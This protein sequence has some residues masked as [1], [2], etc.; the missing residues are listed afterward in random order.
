MGSVIFYTTA[1]RDSAFSSRSI[2]VFLSLTKNHRKKSMVSPIEGLTRNQPV[3]L[4]Y[5]G[6]SYKLADTSDR[7]HPIGG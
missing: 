3:T 5:D 1:D 7:A 6:K 2:R 4:A